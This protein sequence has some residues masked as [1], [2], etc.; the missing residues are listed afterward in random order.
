MYSP[1]KFARTLHRICFARKLIFVRRA[2]W[3]HGSLVER[4][5]VPYD[6]ET[7]IQISV[8][9]VLGLGA[10]RRRSDSSGKVQDLRQ[11]VHV[12]GNGTRTKSLSDT[13]LAHRKK[14]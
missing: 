14:K 2:S 10:A 5:V 13:S 6:S 9:R 7:G 12:V 1:S 4:M 8:P 11:K 3:V